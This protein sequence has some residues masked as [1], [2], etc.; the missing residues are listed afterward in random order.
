MQKTL[1]I[2]AAIVALAASP[3]FAGGY[4]A[5][6]PEPVVAV[7]APLPLTPDWTGFYGGAELGTANVD[8][9]GPGGNDDG[10]IGGLTLGYDYDFGS[11]VVGGALDFDFSDIDIAPGVSTDN[12]FRAKLRGGY[13]I[14]RGLLYATGGYA[15]IDTDGLG[16][17]DGYFIG[18]GY[19]HLVTDNISVGLEA[20]Y[21]KVDNFNGTA[22]DFD[23]TTVQLRA[24]YRF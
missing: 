4:E 14:G 19:E 6:E 23:A 15:N 5:P 3:A 21:H 10:A 22:R 13:K 18:A 7:P 17:D 9:N 16:D 1:A 20:L 11:W 24:I 8:L 12:I 2:F